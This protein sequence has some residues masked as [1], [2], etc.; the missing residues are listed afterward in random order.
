MI[1]KA[2][3]GHGGR[4]GGGWQGNNGIVR[5]GMPNLVDL[6]R[7]DW[8]TCIIWI[9]IDYHFLRLVLIDDCQYFIVVPDRVRS[10]DSGIGKIVINL[11][12]CIW[13]YGLN[14]IGNQ[15][16]SISAKLLLTLEDLLAVEHPT[17]E[18]QPLK[19]Y[20]F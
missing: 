5:K 3:I 8:D 15:D 13:S 12:K 6:C 14:N 9:E 4:S 20:R 1:N 18:F 11:V 17:V 10:F 7:Y 19:I 16:T 2:F